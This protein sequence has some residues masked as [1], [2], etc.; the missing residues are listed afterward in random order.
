MKKNFFVLLIMSM[1]CLSAMADKNIR[2]FS[3]MYYGDF[4]K[5]FDST[6]YA[7]DSVAIEGALNAYDFEMLRQMTVHGRL[8]GIDLTRAKMND[9]YPGISKIPYC[10]FCGFGDMINSNGYIVPDAEIKKK[11]ILEYIKLPLYIYVII[12][13]AFASTGLRTITIPRGI[14]HLSHDA[15]AFNDSLESVCIKEPYPPFVDGEN[16]FANL[17]QSCKLYVPVG[18]KQYYMAVDGWNEIDPERIVEDPN[19]LV[20]TTVDLRGDDLMLHKEE[21]SKCDSLIITGELTTKDSKL[22]HEIYVSSMISGFNLSGCH[23]EGDSIPTFTFLMHSDTLFRHREYLGSGP[24]MYITFPAG[25]KKICQGAVVRS[26][27]QRLI[28][29]VGLE[30]IS[31]TAFTD[32]EYLFS[33]VVIPEGIR[34][35]PY[36]SFDG[37][38]NIPEIRIPSSVEKLEPYSIYFGSEPG[39]KRD[40]YIDRMT[41][42]L[43]DNP[44]AGFNSEEL[45]TLYVPVGAKQNYLDAPYFKDFYSIIETPELTG[46]PTAIDGVESGVTERDNGYA[47]GVYTLDGKRIADTMTDGMAKGLYVVKR[48]AVISKV[49]VR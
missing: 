11:S 19:L 4:A 28:L 35:M 16:P 3:N 43:A 10:A 42:P 36:G 46:G 21:V 41:P 40:I 17:P 7:I 30:S 1:T 2:S 13:L 33:P 38:L 22:L 31:K 27:L 49:A 8:K 24:L 47:D 20:I 39:F 37:S 48:G 25:L 44:F 29:P 18:S 32:N 34:T 45:C 15:L 12:T 6:Y 9:G 26:R 14:R 23:V 5:S